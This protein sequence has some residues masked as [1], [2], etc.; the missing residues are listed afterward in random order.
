MQVK[1]LSIRTLF[2]LLCF[3]GVVI[4]EEVLSI[5]FLDYLVEFEDAEGEW[6]DPMELEMMAQLNQ[7][8]DGQSSA[9]MLESE[10]EGAPGNE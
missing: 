1:T 6:V 8:A 4:A 10:R 7:H 3:T 9:I 5:E 2:I